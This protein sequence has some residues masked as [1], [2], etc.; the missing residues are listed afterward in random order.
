MKFLHA[1]GSRPLDGYTIKRGIGSGGFGEVYYAVSDA[2]K[3]VA[4]K[5]I[6]R[7]LEVELR[8]V[9]QCLNLKHPH[10]VAL[11][12][13]RRDGHDDAWVVMEFVRG[14]SLETILA[15]HP[16]GLPVA[17][18]LR[19]M[20]GICAGVDYLHEQGLVHRDLKPGNLF[21]ED[22]LV[23]IGDYGLSKFIS[24]SR[25]SGQ[26]E[27]VGT[28]HYMAPEVANG[29]YGKEID[30]YAM[31]IILYEML[32]GS[33]P[34][35]GESVGEVLMKHLTAEPDLQRL[36]QEFRRVVGGALTKDPE[37]RFR[38]VAALRAALPATPATAGA[39]HDGPSLP[40]ARV[41]GIDRGAGAP[42]PVRPGCEPPRQPPVVAPAGG[43]R[44]AVPAAAG[45]RAEPEEPILRALSRTWQSLRTAWQTADL[46]GP[47]RAVATVVF[48]VALLYTSPFWIFGVLVFSVLYAVY[49]LIRALLRGGG[50]PPPTPDAQ[51]GGTPAAPPPGQHVAA[52]AGRAARREA[53]PVR[54]EPA[55]AL[56]LKPPRAKATELLG[57]LLL[58]ATVTATLCLVTSLL[59]RPAGNPAQFVWLG[60]VATAA[61]WAI[62]VPSKFWEGHRGEPILRRF[63]LLCVG[64]GLGF[65][66]W[67][68]QERLLVDLTS[69]PDF[70]PALF[71]RPAS[72]LSWQVYLGYFGFLFPALRW[73][74]LADPLRYTRFSLV[75]TCVCVF[76][77]WLLNV[78]WPFPQPWGLMLAAIVAISVQLSSPWVDPSASPAAH[79]PHRET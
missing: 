19:W 46:P 38:T 62:L 44:A 48:I 45:A 3:E 72:D 58:S 15:Q 13:V 57:S 8:G 59:A 42:P 35:E 55:P 29:R 61:S 4:L 23:K 2:G 22:G 33:V 63:G 21:L 1:S 60:L 49:A 76:W 37:R 16:Q 14:P 68:L 47:I 30:L 26:T 40:V 64:L 18:V 51:R 24:T 79:R 41:L 75:S 6:R 28:V 70:L 31:G 50:M 7:N 17:E 65:A 78:L 32:T 66:A 34:F 73:W 77:A 9:T 71:P 52:S 5:L 36:P 20:H 69:N 11:Y 27:S 54:A 25:R 74:K 12:D 10:L 39:G 53:R 43:Y 56:P 67:W